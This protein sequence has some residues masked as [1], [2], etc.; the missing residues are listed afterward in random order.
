M[1]NRSALTELVS[2]AGMIGWLAVQGAV[3]T[4]VHASYTPSN[5]F[6]VLSGVY[7]ICGPHSGAQAAMPLMHFPSSNFAIIKSA[8]PPP[9]SGNALK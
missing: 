9:R 6:A 7:S 4:R 2:R 1:S 5:G 8:F 3:L